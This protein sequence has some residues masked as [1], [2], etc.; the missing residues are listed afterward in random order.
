MQPLTE[1]IDDFEKHKK[2]PPP[3][4]YFFLCNNLR[5]TIAMMLEE[6]LGELPKLLKYTIQNVSPLKWGDHTAVENWLSGKTKTKI[7]SIQQ[8][9]PTTKRIELE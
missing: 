9:L 7:S 1:L 3:F 2:R 4:L 5:R 6:S 8:K